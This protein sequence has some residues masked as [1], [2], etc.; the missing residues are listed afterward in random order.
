MWTMCLA[1]IA[2]LSKRKPSCSYHKWVMD[3]MSKDLKCS[4]C[5]AEVEELRWKDKDL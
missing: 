4:E 5:G 1:Y 2:R 3:D